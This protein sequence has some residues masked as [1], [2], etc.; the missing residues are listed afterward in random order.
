M[1][2]WTWVLMCVLLYL[3][4]FMLI[5]TFKSE[6]MFYPEPANAKISVP[7]MPYEDVFFQTTD[8]ETLHAWYIPN[9]VQDHDRSSTSSS[10]GTSNPSKAPKT[11]RTLVIFLHGA[12]GKG[13][14]RITEQHNLG[15]A[16]FACNYRG[17]G[18]STGQPTPEGVMLDV[19][20]TWNYVTQV[21]HYQPQEIILYGYSLGTSL[22]TWLGALRHPRMVIL[23]APFSS[24]S[25]LVPWLVRP[26]FTWIITDFQTATYIKELTCPVVIMASVDDEAI[27]YVYAQKLYNTVPHPNK[28]FIQVTGTHSTLHR[29]PKVLQLLQHL[30]QL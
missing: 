14:D 21:L 13:L 30:S 20:T 26:F 7:Q 27:P 2:L 8:Q 28:T 19:L 5:D 18:K 10:T 16:I 23:E 9:R 4:F 17:F 11:L 12:A 15:H 6:F 22:A 29:N 25:D 3:L 1:K 24:L